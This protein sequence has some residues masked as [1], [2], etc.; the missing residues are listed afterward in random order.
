MIELNGQCAQDEDVTIIELTADVWMMGSDA[1]GIVKRIT[2]TGSA[3]RH[4]N[5]RP[6]SRIGLEV[7]M[8]RAL[9]A[10]ADRL[11]KDA[12]EDSDG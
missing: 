6:S 9:R 3:K 2:A 8:A 4:P 10:M 5:D 12:L 11:E 1:L 7:A